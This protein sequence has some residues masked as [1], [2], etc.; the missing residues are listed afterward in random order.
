MM[1][2]PCISS[3]NVCYHEVSFGFSVQVRMDKCPQQ[4]IQHHLA[5]YWKLMDMG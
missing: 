5:P 2:Q 3:W 4:K 1:E